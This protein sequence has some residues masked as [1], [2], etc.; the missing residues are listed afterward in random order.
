M[1]ILLLSIKNHIVTVF[2]VS[3]VAS[4]NL[5]GVLIWHIFNPDFGEE[6]FVGDE[7]RKQT[8]KQK[9]TSQQH[10]LVD[11]ASFKSRPTQLLM[12]T[13]TTQVVER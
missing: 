3:C 2:H 12:F 4:V 1:E 13:W 5:C 10:H 8:N 11:I 9:Q 7:P 6:H